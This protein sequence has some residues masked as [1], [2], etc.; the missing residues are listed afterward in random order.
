MNTNNDPLTRI[1]TAA[2]VLLVAA[3]AATV[4]FVHIAHLALTHGQTFLAAVLLPLSIDGTVAAAA[5][6]MLR[7][8]RGGLGTPWLARFMLTLAVVATLAANI[9]YGVPYGVAGAL[10]SGWPAVAF[11]GCA[12]MAIGMV[13]RTRRADA[14]EPV[15]E[16]VLDKVPSDVLEAAKVWY[17]AT[18]K[19]GNPASANRVRERFPLTVAQTKEMIAT[20]SLNGHGHQ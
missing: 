14:T 6:V 9:G 7:A 4:S 12:E 17:A 10:L 2:A 11:I 19:V 16:S 15:Q 1:G 20:V 18:L 8:A 3:I 5:L 13:R